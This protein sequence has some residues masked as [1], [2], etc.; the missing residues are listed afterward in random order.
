MKLTLSSVGPAASFKIN[1]QLPIVIGMA[2]M[3]VAYFLYKQ[4][5]TESFEQSKQLIIIHKTPIHLI[6]KVILYFYTESRSISITRPLPELIF[7]H[8]TQNKHTVHV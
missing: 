3:E 1:A 4:S 5:V 8:R 6:K 2:G 7:P